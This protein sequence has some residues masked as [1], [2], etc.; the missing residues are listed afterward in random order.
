MKKFLSSNVILILMFCLGVG[1]LLYPT[2]SNY[3][4]QYHQ[5]KVIVDYSRKVEDAG[6]EKTLEVLEAAISYNKSLV[7]NS[8]GH[9]LGEAEWEKYAKQ[10]NIAGDG[11]MGYVEIEKLETSLPIYHGTSEEVLQSAIGHLEWTSLPVGGSGSH[12]VISGHRGLPSAKLFTDLDLLQEGDRFMLHT[13]GDT[14]IY[15]VDQILIVEPGDVEALKV[16]EGEDFCT[17]MTC[18]PY[19]INTH[20]LLVRVKRVKE[21]NENMD[22]HTGDATQVGV[23]YLV[24]FAV[25][26]ALL[27]RFILFGYTRKKGKGGKES[28]EMD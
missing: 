18:T 2:I 9:N 28:V 27:I 14:L 5:S 1:M 23:G 6:D 19:G 20:R 25:A 4:N 10:L 3:W 15:Q 16:V 21:I 8:I 17:L 22:Y 11:V 13:L 24:G 12:C 26:V 7:G